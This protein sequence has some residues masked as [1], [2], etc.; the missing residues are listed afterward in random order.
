MWLFQKKGAQE[1]I[2]RSWQPQEPLRA[3]LLCPLSGSTE[4]TCDETDRRRR[5]RQAEFLEWDAGSEE[6][7]SSCL[8]ERN[9]NAEMDGSAR[10]QS[11]THAQ[12][13]SPFVSILADLVEANFRHPQRRNKQSSKNWQQTTFNG[14]SSTQRCRSWWISF[15]QLVCRVED[16]PIIDELAAEADGRF[17]VVKVNAFDEQDLASHYRIAPSPRCSF[18]RAGWW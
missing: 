17:R 18:S 2:Q 7:F 12:T 3:T 11:G 14:R 1:C 9:G 15:H 8:M 13:L 16:A 10:R 4:I 6:G 5:S